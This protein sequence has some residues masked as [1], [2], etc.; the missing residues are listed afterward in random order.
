M[1]NKLE[2]TYLRRAL[3]S[4]LKSECF[5]LSTSAIPQGYILARMG[6]PSISISSSEP[7]MAKGRRAYITLERRVSRGCNAEQS[8]YAEFTVVLNCLL[9]ILF[10][11]IWEIVDRN[12]VML[13]VL[14]D[15]HENYQDQK[16]Q[17]NKKLSTL[18]LKPLSSLGVRESALPMTGMTL[19]RGERRRINSISISLNLAT[20]VSSVVG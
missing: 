3:R 4:L 5:G 2:E 16:I 7:M 6:W 11:I 10:D 19:T 8:T 14:H 1:L 20:H 12:I 13:D 15:L 9:V 17:E 18:F